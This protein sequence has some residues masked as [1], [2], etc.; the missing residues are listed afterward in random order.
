MLV[1]MTYQD[2]YRFRII[3]RVHDHTLLHREAARLLKITV[4]QV[5]RVL[6]RYRE[7]GAASTV[8]ECRGS[9]G[10]NHIPYDSGCAALHLI[11]QHYADLG[12]TLAPGSFWNDTVLCVSL[13]SDSDLLNLVSVKYN[14]KNINAVCA[15]TSN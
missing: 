5:Q 12:P 14:N 10:N 2:Q 7:V 3:Q 9:P 11:R 4:R 15:C 6:C 1:T 8:S 13:F